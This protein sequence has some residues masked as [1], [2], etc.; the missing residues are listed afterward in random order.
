M[1]IRINW[2]GERVV[3]LH[4]LLIISVNCCRENNY[5]CSL[6]LLT[7][8]SNNKTNFKFSFCFG[9]TKCKIIELQYFQSN[10][11]FQNQLLLPLKRNRVRMK[12]VLKI[13]RFLVKQQSKNVSLVYFICLIRRLL[14][15]GSEEF[16]GTF[17]LRNRRDRRLFK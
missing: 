6:E 16:D 13:L 3:H 4:L 2:R 12:K 14:E 9:L 5:Y 11:L 7:L 17:S 10:S 15:G 8:S 1:V